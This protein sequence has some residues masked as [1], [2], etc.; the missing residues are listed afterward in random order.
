MYIFNLNDNC[1]KWM[2]S[3]LG[4]SWCKDDGHRRPCETSSISVTTYVD[5]PKHYLFL[6]KGDSMTVEFSFLMISFFRDRLGSSFKFLPL[7][8][9]VS[10]IFPLT[11]DNWCCFVTFC[12]HTSAGSHSCFLTQ[13]APVWP[14][15]PHPAPLFHLLPADSWSLC[16]AKHSSSFFKSH[17]CFHFMAFPNHSI[18]LFSTSS[19][20][21]TLHP[22]SQAS[23]RS[24]FPS[25]IPFSLVTLFHELLSILT[26]FL[27]CPFAPFKF[28][29]LQCSDWEIPRENWFLLFTPRS[30]SEQLEATITEKVW[31][32][33]G[34]VI[35]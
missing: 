4:R 24:S 33:F 15:C 30:L 14:S 8:G 19:S 34:K 23:C 7:F 22:P 20:L 12:T 16:L 29:L 11:E 5:D 6:S 13:P 10:A 25:H 17:K 3:I 35:S 1:L 27:M 26:V 31:F 21:W 28:P 9:D 32:E 18:S 2:I